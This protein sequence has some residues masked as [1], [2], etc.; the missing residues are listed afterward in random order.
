[1][2]RR[3]T[4]LQREIRTLSLLVDEMAKEEEVC[5]GSKNEIDFM[6]LQEQ[7][8]RNRFQKHRTESYDRDLKMKYC[9]VLAGMAGLA[10][11]A[12]AKVKQYYF[13]S[14]ILGEKSSNSVLK[15]AAEDASISALEGSKLLA[16]E[17]AEEDKKIFMLDMLLM[18]SLSGDIEEKQL[19]YFCELATYFEVGQKVQESIVGV[20]ACILKDENEEVYLHAKYF[21][22][23]YIS[24]YLTEAIPAKVVTSIEDI[25][26][27]NDSFVI[28]A[29]VNF[30][31]M[32]VWIEQY[33]K[34]HIRFIKCSFENVSQISAGKTI[35]EFFDCIFENC[36]REYEVSSEFCMPD[37]VVF[38]DAKWKGTNNSSYED[39][40]M[41]YKD[42]EYH[43]GLMEFEEA[44][45]E[46]C[47]F[48]QCS[49]INNP[50]LST[51]LMLK[52][53]KVINCLFKDCIVGAQCYYRVIS[54]KIHLGSRER[55]SSEL[56]TV[57]YGGDV[58]VTECEF[59]GCKSCG[60]GYF[61]D[62]S[63][64]VIPGNYRYTHMIYLN[65]GCVESC[66]FTSCQCGGIGREHLTSLLYRRGTTDSHSYLLNC[67]QAMEKNNTFTKC[68]AK[69]YVCSEK[70]KMLME[71]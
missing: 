17:L 51:I 42:M 40:C 54:M 7:G 1:M 39:K 18:I 57:L 50:I 61:D 30:K 64:E 41:G 20:V 28:V 4:D 24:C 25:T 6:T 53:G 67:F 70:W 69:G 71:W 37:I 19:D 5:D 58:S 68:E 59:I 48:I 52:K 63:R 44:Y 47:Q 43:L 46:K 16:D 62:Y 35:V 45:F 21:P 12:E 36:K 60:N 8:Y 2:D 66:E 32:D 15:S 33:H 34:K 23:F 56:G 3:V 10:E 27:L 9:T 65:S 31:N 26:K 14:R 29:G 22:V 13:V 11:N 49:I 55:E 38:Q